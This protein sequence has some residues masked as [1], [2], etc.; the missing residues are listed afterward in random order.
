MSGE[1][2]AAGVETSEPTGSDVIERIDRVSQLLDRLEET[3]D[4]LDSL[5]C[6]RIQTIA[7]GRKLDVM[8]K[9]ADDLAARL[10]TAADGVL[11]VSDGR[12]RNSQVGRIDARLRQVEDGW[13]RHADLHTRISDALERI[14]RKLAERLP[15]AKGED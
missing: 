8:S 6:V 4:L 2:D 14:D 10:Q 15:S 12:R 9:T 3:S 5:E 11:S 7:L 1:Q 13:N